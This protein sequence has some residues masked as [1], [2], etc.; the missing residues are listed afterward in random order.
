M[1]ICKNEL[2]I[3]DGNENRKLKN[4]YLIFV[5]LGSFDGENIFTWR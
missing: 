5:F 4:I 1:L 2:I 3:A